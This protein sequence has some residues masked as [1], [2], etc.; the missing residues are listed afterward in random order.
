AAQP[1]VREAR[2]AAQRPLVAEQPGDRHLG[3]EP[4]ERLAL[5]LDAERGLHLPSSGSGSGP[6]PPCASV[7]AIASS[8]PFTNAGE[9][10]LPKRR[11]SSIAS[12]IAIEAGVPPHAIS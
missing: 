7:R 3:G 4:R 12:S 5:H 6:G 8:T 9:R 11:A 1:P 2:A 10:S